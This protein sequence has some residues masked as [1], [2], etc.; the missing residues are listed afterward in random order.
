ME[1]D[2]IETTLAE[3][4]SEQECGL[5]FREVKVFHPLLFAFHPILVCN[6][7]NRDLDFNLFDFEPHSSR[8]STWLA[9]PVK[10]ESQPQS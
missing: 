3:K 6:A 4:V 5:N 8:P 9:L 7:A 2:N 10:T 1:G